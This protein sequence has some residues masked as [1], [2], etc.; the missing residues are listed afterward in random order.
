VPSISRLPSAVADNAVPLAVTIVGAFLFRRLLGSVVS[1]IAMLAIGRLLLTAL[2]VDLAL[3][4]RRT[5]SAP[6]S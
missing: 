5:H 4:Q 2:K 3:A 6:R 1:V